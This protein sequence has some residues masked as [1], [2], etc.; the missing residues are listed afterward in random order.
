MPPSLL[1][2]GEI[3]PLVLNPTSQA[4]AARAA[5]TATAASCRG[6]FSVSAT[7]TPIPAST[8][9]STASLMPAAGT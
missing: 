5:A 9:S 8:A 1:L 6:T 2:P 4:P 3:T 7:M